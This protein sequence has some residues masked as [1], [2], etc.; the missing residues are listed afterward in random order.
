MLSTLPSL[1]NV[2]PDGGPLLHPELKKPLRN[3]WRLHF[4]LSLWGSVVRE[5]P[6][7]SLYFCQAGPLAFLHPLPPF[8]WLSPPPAGILIPAGAGLQRGTITAAPRL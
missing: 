4:S 2:H 6:L 1:P 7:G 5:Q 8:S 3:V